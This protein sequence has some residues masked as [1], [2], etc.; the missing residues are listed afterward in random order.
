MHHHVFDRELLVQMA[1]YSGLKA[2]R[3]DWM[4]PYHIIM[5]AKKA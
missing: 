1:D 3:L 5:L 2:V 4:N